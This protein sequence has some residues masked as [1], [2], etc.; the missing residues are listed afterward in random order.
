IDPARVERGSRLVE[1]LG[2]ASLDLV[3]L[4]AAFEEEFGVILP[5][6]KMSEATVG[7]LEQAVLEVTRG[8]APAT[9]PAIDS[10]SAPMGSIV[11]GSGASPQSSSASPETGRLPAGATAAGPTETLPSQQPGDSAPAVLQAASSAPSG[12]PAS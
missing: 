1:G 11:P 9:Q 6:E 4:G 12:P 5:E 10:G 2:L 3:E 8:G 7:D